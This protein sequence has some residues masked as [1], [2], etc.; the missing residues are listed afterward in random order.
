[1]LAHDGIARTLYFLI[2]RLLE[3]HWPVTAVLS[4]PV[5]TKSGD[6]LLD[7]TTEQWNLLAELKSILHI[8]QVHVAT[9][10]L[11]A[12]YNVSISAL[13]PIIH[14]LTKSMEVTD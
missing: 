11:S 7:L 6:R 4:D 2:D 10:Y 14:G 1:M 13:L 9:T 5:V 8:L 3:Q 12:E